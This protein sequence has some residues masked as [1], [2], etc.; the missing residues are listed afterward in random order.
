MNTGSMDERQYLANIARLAKANERIADA[1]ERIAAALEAREAPRDADAVD[2]SRPTRWHLGPE[3]EDGSVEVTIEQPWTEYVTL[4]SGKRVTVE[5]L[6]AM[7]ADWEERT[8]VS[9]L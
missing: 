2:L 1:N 5:E 8:R 3:D 9:N 4:R 7:E 6:E